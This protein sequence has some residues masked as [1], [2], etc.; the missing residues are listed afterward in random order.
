MKVRRC[1]I[2]DSPI[3]NGRCKVCG[4]PY[5]N[6][7]EMYHLNE[8]RRDHYKHSSPQVRERLL[9][10]ERP[11]P[12]KR[13]KTTASS[14]K[15]SVGAYTSSGRASGVGTSAKG[16]KT[17]S[18]AE[19]KPK[20]KTWLLILIGVLCLLEILP[21]LTRAAEDFFYELPGIFDEFGGHEEVSEG[22]RLPQHV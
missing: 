2:C 7:E 22:T 21:L 16:G 10:L 13:T 20:K 14:G 12:A 3:V 11:K 4:M 6:D 1:C 9:S 8:N 18:W 5:R 19:K 15:K 17:V